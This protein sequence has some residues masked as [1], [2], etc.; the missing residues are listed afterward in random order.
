[1]PTIDLCHR[2]SGAGRAAAG[3]GSSRLGMLIT[4]AVVAGLCGTSA[5]ARADAR[6]ACV[7]IS[8]SSTPTRAPLALDAER[9]AWVAGDRAVAGLLGHEWGPYKPAGHPAWCDAEDGAKCE[10][11][12]QAPTQ[13]ERASSSAAGAELTATADVVVTLVFGRPALAHPPIPRGQGAAGT[14]TELE[15]PPRGR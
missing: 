10:R 12:D 5:G 7:E 13:S 11:G 3:A 9:A 6:G 8:A 4:T 2:S 14:R 1:M 15:R